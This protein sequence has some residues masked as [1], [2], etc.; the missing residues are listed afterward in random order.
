MAAT[1]KVN[2][3]PTPFV[4]AKMKHIRI[5]GLLFAM[6]LGGVWATL[7]AAAPKASQLVENAAAKMRSAQSVTVRFNAA[8]A[9]SGILSRGTLT[10]SSSKFFIDTPKAKVWY[11]G[12]TQW[13]WSADAGEVNI[14][15]PTVEEIAEVNPY[16][17][18]NSLRSRY[19]ASYIGN[20]SQRTV[21][22]TPSMPRPTV[23]RAEITFSAD[24]FPS[25][26]KLNMSTGETLTLTITSVKTGGKLPVSTFSFTPAKAPGAE[27]VDLR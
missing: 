4:N 7:S 21:L 9:P 8:A 27:I 24:G 17:I 3:D 2:L 11:D 15:E 1:C 25:R 14:T 19:K 5:L 12:K 13:S 23:K 26:M 20:P 18:I 10:I 22:L 16:A 6:L